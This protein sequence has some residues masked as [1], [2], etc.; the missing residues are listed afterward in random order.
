MPGRRASRDLQ[1]TP[2]RGHPIKLSYGY[3]PAEKQIMFW[4][5]AVCLIALIFLIAGMNRA[6][7]RDDGRYANSPL[8]PWF[9][10]LKNKQSVPCCDTADGLRLEDV[11][12]ESTGKSYRV[13]INGQWYDVPDEAVL[14]QPNKLGPAVVWPTQTASGKVQIRCFI[15]GAGT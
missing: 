12:W 1:T 4:A 6:H 13:R 14:E 9:D 11:D 5:V 2:I 3:R 15:A 8:K 7:S 10:S